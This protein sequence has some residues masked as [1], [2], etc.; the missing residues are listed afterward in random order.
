M[1]PRMNQPNPPPPSLSSAIAFSSFHSANQTLTRHPH[2]VHRRFHAPAESGQPAP[3]SAEPDIPAGRD[4]VYVLDGLSHLGQRLFYLFVRRIEQRFHSTQ[5]ASEPDEDRR[6]GQCHHQGGDPERDPHEALT[7]H[8]LHTP[9]APAANTSA[10]LSAGVSEVWGETRDERFGDPGGPD[11]GEATSSAASAWSI[12]ER[13]AQE[14]S[15]EM[16]RM[17]AED[18]SGAFSPDL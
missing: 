16:G 7:A 5:G 9:A 4:V 15:P 14:L 3:A 8:R 13:A 6:Q 10:I 18:P 12:R 2:A 1:P 11:P 17:G